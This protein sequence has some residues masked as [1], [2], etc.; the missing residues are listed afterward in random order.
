MIEFSAVHGWHAA[1]HLESPTVRGDHYCHSTF[2]RYLQCV[3]VLIGYRYR[4]PWHSPE[5]S[6]DGTMDT[7]N[8]VVEHIDVSMQAFLQQAFTAIIVWLVGSL[9]QKQNDDEQ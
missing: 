5:L 2:H 6:N 1:P 8:A 3:V 7:T 4:N 9:V